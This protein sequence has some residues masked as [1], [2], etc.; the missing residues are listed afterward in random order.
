M[1]IKIILLLSLGLLLTNCNNSFSE[2]PGEPIT[3]HSNV[4]YVNFLQSNSGNFDDSI[5]MNTEIWDK[6]L[7]VETKFHDEYQNEIPVVINKIKKLSYHYLLITFTYDNTTITVISSVGGGEFTKINHIPD[8]WEKIHVNGSGRDDTYIY[9]VTGTNLYRLHLSSMAEKIMNP[10]DN[11]VSNKSRLYSNNTDSVVSLYIT[12][13]GVKQFY[14]FNSSGELI[15]DMKN[16]ALV[17][18]F[19]NIVKQNSSLSDIFI[20]EKRGFI[21]YYL[22]KL[23]SSNITS[24]LMTFDDELGLTSKA[25]EVLLTYNT[26]G[27]FKRFGVGQMM[28]DNSIFTNGDTIIRFS[29]PE[30]HIVATE[31]SF[32][33]MIDSWANLLDSKYSYGSL[34]CLF[35]YPVDGEKKLVRLDLTGNS[36]V[37]EIIASG[38]IQSFSP[39]DYLVFYK[40]SSGTYYRNLETNEV[41]DYNIDPSNILVV[42]KPYFH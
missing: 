26:T 42:E 19:Y 12:D 34:Y 1:K 37:E 25:E 2:P 8:D 15:Q 6:S 18:Q 32:S 28:L 10:I 3:F 5:L 36:T 13:L 30:S 27:S 33:A 7:I 23:N 21:F 4:C 14:L 24:Q 31:Y 20:L 16:Q 22:V 9:Y 35:D 41:R 38:N 40:D 29:Y 39:T 17:D 11:P